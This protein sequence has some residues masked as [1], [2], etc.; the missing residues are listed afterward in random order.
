[1]KKHWKG[2]KPEA[3]YEIGRIYY[4]GLGVEPDTIKAISMF[5]LNAGDKEVSSKGTLALHFYNAKDTLNALKY[6]ELA[7][8][9]KD[10]EAMTKMG[11][12]LIEWEN[13]KDVER[14]LK[15]VTEAADSNYAKAAY[16]LSCYYSNPHYGIKT[17]QDKAFKYALQAA[18]ADYVPAYNTVFWSYYAGEGTPKDINQALYWVNKGCEAEDAESYYYKGMLYYNGDGVAKDTKTG[19]ELLAK[20]AE[21]GDTDAQAMLDK[22]S[23]NAAARARAQAKRDKALKDAI[24]SMNSATFLYQN[25]IYF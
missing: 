22:I 17:N 14:G 3:A 25:G 23:G 21:M 1:M 6:G 9:L 24:N 13:V 20:A 12:M 5:D 4:E 8:N 19:K 11:K 7:A 10:Y 15:Y 2:G 18:Q 16:N